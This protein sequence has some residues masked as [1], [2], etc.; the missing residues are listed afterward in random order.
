MEQL[1]EKVCESQY[2]EHYNK[3]NSG[4]TD[5]TPISGISDTGRSY[6][7]YT[8]TKQVFGN[9]MWRKNDFLNHTKTSSG[10]EQN[11]KSGEY[12][13]HLCTD[14]LYHTSVQPL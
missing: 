7:Q 9:I 8:L 4:R 5:F 10:G 2:W 12:S 1:V 11:G 6:L 14:K 3:E 13:A